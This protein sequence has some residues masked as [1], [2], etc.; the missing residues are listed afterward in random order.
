MKLDENSIK[1]YNLTEDEISLTMNGYVPKSIKANDYFLKENEICN[2]IGFV[3]KGLFRSFFYDDF[4]N[5]ITTDFFPEGTLII[6]FDSFNNR[7]PSKEYIKANEDSELMT[8]SYKKQKELYNKIPA[9][10]QICKDLAD[11]K[12]REMI[13]RAKQFQTMKATERYQTFCKEHPDILQRTTLGHIASYLGIDIATL[14]RIRRK[15]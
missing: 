13:E 7:T 12:S 1:K 9:W 10:N 5:E 8:I 15:K 14:S 11:L 6:A 4:A 2:Y 3:T